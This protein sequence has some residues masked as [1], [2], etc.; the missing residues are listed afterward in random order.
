M[1]FEVDLWVGGKTAL[2][3][4]KLRYWRQNCVATRTMTLPIALYTSPTNY[5]IPGWGTLKSAQ[6]LLL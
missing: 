5:N 2:L 4:A 6:S 3:E 1:V